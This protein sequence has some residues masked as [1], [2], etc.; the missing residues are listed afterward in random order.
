MERLPLHPGECLYLHQAV[1]GLSGA[2]NFV[3]SERPLSDRFADY[4]GLSL[5]TFKVA[6]AER[7]GR[8]KL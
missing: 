3:R 2:K 1:N 4:Q 7:S 6:S 5:L 8:R